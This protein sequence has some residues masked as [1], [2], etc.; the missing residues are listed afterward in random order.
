MLVALA[1]ARE[2]NFAHV[3]LAIAIRIFE[4][5]DFR[6]CSDDHAIP[7]DQQAGGE[8]QPLGKER[9]FLV[10]AIA[11]HILQNTHPTTRLALAIQTQRIVRHFH[12]PHATGQI[13]INRNRIH[14]LG[15]MGHTLHA[16]SIGHV[17]LL[18]RLLRA[19]RRGGDGIYIDECR[20]SDDSP[21]PIMRGDFLSRQGPLINGWFIQFPLPAIQSI[22]ASTE[23]NP[24][25]TSR[26]RVRQFPGQLRLR[27]AIKMD[28][29]VVTLAHQHHMMPGFLRKNGMAHEQF[30]ARIAIEQN[31]LAH[32]VRTERAADAQMLATGLRVAFG[33]A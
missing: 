24:V 3:G 17:D 10:G 9:G 19:E 6:C 26:H 15:F 20:R 7:P 31:E 33:S 30:I 14:G 11:I 18:D 13:P 12:D 21:S 32:D 25:D 5:Q 29:D 8:I 22:V 23:E 1:E 27:M 16:E 28:P 4:K 2:Q